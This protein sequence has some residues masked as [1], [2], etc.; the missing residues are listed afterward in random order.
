[1]TPGVRSTRHVVYVPAQADIAPHHCH[2]IRPYRQ[3]CIH[4]LAAMRIT[5]SFLTII[6]CITSKSEL[7]QEESQRENQIEGGP[8]RGSSQGVLRPQLTYPP[9]QDHHMEAPQAEVKTIF[10]PNFDSPG[11]ALTAAA[12]ML[13]RDNETV[14]TAFRVNEK[15]RLQEGILAMTDGVITYSTAGG[16][17]SL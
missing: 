13:V 15:T 14:A 2:V 3:P 5:R 12:N 8:A 6:I 16:R 4:S 9:G 10:E 17:A 7:F 1:M 11:E